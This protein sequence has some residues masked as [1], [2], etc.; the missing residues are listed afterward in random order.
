MPGRADR[1]NNPI[2]SLE[3]INILKTIGQIAPALAV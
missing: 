1:S 2:K 3:M